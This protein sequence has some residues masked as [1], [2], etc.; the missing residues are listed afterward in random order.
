MKYLLPLLILVAV[1]AGC[2]TAASDKANYEP[3]DYIA[4]TIVWQGQPLHC[5]VLDSGWGR[6][7]DSGISCDWQRYH[8]ENG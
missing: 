1:L 4:V 3:D 8:E 2:D 7:D 6:S 5:I